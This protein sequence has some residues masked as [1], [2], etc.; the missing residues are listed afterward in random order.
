MNG[1][2]KQQQ[3]ENILLNPDEALTYIGVELPDEGF[4]SCFT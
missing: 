3:I 4:R 2:T 1:H